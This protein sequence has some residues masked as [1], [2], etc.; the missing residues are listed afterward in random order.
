[1]LKND[2]DTQFERQ[3]WHRTEEVSV[4]P[5]APC[6]YTGPAAYP[7]RPRRSCQCKMKYTSSFINS[8]LSGAAPPTPLERASVRLMAERMCMT[9]DPE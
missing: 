9:F 2:G 8:P 6:H 3:A 4:C 7:T 5:T 1:M